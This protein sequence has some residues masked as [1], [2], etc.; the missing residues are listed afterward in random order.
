[1]GWG[2]PEAA[3]QWQRDFG[4][5]VRELRLGAGLSQMQ[6]AHLADLDPT[7]LSAVE[8]GR[9]NLGLVNIFQIA[10]ALD[11]PVRELFPAEEA[12]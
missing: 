11:L 2:K 10:R 8:Q 5:R 3:E 4:A 6:L 12:P 1:M 7:Y 9:R